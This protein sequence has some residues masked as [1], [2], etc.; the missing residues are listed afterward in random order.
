[1]NPFMDCILLSGVTGVSTSQCIRTA[2]G[3]ESARV[4]GGLK[5]GE[6]SKFLAFL[7]DSDSAKLH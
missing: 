6:S 2:T 7:Q 4:G 3:D 5:L 1:M